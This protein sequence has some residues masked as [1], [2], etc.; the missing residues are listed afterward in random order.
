M[1]AKRPGAR[2]GLV[3]HRALATNSAHLADEDRQSAERLGEPASAPDQP[4]IGCPPSEPEDSFLD[5]GGR[6]AVDALMHVFRRLDGYIPP[7]YVALF[8]H[9][10][11]V[12]LVQ[13][14]RPLRGGL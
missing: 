7:K 4:A 12:C 14:H 11:A 13:F 3:E 2:S 10:G 8:F 5:T 1:T 9:N 6:T